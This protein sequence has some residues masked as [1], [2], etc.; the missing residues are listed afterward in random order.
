MGERTGG[1][2]KHVGV[3]I[4][5]CLRFELSSLSHILLM[6]MW[7]NVDHESMML[8]GRTFQFQFVKLHF[9]RFVFI[10]DLQIPNADFV[11]KY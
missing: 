4:S 2:E 8:N 7:A 5:H 1:I 6:V 10:L 3:F 11:P 9:E